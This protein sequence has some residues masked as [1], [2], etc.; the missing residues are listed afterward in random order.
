MQH[1][2]R[3]ADAEQL[4]EAHVAGGEGEEHHRDQQRGGG[5]DAAGAL[6]ADGHRQLVV[7]GAVVLLLDAGE[8]E[9]LVVHRQAEGDAEHQDRRRGVDA[10][11]GGEVEDAGRGGRPGRSRP[12]RRRWRDRLSRLSTSALIGTTTLPNIRNSSTN[13]TTAMIPSGQRQLD[14][15]RRP[16]MS[17]S[18][19]R[20]AAD[21]HV[22]RRRRS[23][24]TSRDERAR[25]RRDSGSTSGTTDRYVLPPAPRCE[26]EV[27]AVAARRAPA[28]PAM[29]PSVGQALAAVGAGDGVDPGTPWTG[30]SWSRRRRSRR[31]ASA[32]RR[33]RWRRRR[34]A[35]ASCELNSSRMT[36]CDLAARPPRRQHP[37]VGQAELDARGTGCRGTAARAMARRRRTGPAGA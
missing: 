20:L 13:V 21:A 34:A 26:A 7:A 2:Q 6:E 18:C 31:C 30:A 4:D 33:C 1:G 19:G 25:P 17:T 8:Q 5:D 27:A 16:S 12:S 37:V 15:Q 22:E 36:S 24:R 32:G 23:P 9:H 29:Q 14:E 10:A 3:E 11:G 28:G 35:P